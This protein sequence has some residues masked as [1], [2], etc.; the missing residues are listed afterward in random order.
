MTDKCPLCGAPR[1]WEQVLKQV[2]RGSQGDPAWGPWQERRYGAFGLGD[3]S[4][5]PAG[6]EYERRRP[7]RDPA[8]ESDV[9]TPVLQSVMSGAVGA[10]LAGAGA[11]LLDAS[12]PWAVAAL[13][14][15][16]VLGLTWYVLLREHRGLLWEIERVT[17]ADIDGDGAVGAPEAK[18]T[19]VEVT[20]RTNGHTRMRFVDVPLSDAE[21]E[22]VARAVLVQRERFSRR[23]LSGVLSQSQY[24]DVYD[25]M[26]GGGL[27]RDRSDGRGV[28]LSPSGRAFLGQYLDG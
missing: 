21:L 7:V 26:L 14:G 22:S 6:A 13:G 27:L 23:G 2:Q 19:R 4:A 17:G 10:I 9:I 3:V 18:T 12:K 16:G 25:A 1:N 5:L 24:A 15:A 20:E 11:V 8:I 28:E